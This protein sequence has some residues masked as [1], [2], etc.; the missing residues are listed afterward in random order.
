MRAVHDK[1]IE[2]GMESPYTG[3]RL[4]RLLAGAQSDAP[5][6]I[7]ISGHAAVVREGLLAHATQVDPN[8]PHWFGLPPDVA[9]A[10][11]PFEEYDVARDLTGV[12]GTMDDLFLGVDAVAAGRA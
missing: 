1:F 4:D 3:E 7:D 10:L 2:L 8:S 12:E 5:V 11:Y 6:V 9:D